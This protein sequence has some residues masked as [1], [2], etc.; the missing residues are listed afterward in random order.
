M[1]NKKVFPFATLLVICLAAIACE[2]SAGMQLAGG[3]VSPSE[4]DAGQTEAISPTAKGSP[5]SHRT[6]TQAFLDTMRTPV[7]FSMG[8]FELYA[9]NLVVLPSDNR[10]AMYTMAR[11]RM[12]AAT[13]GTRSQFQ[14]DYSFGY[15]QYNRRREVHS[16]EHT[17]IM[18]YS[19]Q[20][21]PNTSLHI[22]DDFRSAR[23]DRSTL[24]TS[25][26]PVLYQPNFAQAL[27]LPGERFTNNSLMT[28]LTYRA[29]KRS[30]VTLFSSYDFWRYGGNSFGNAHGIQAGIRAD[31]QM[32]K[33]FF[34]QSSYSHYLNKM[35]RTFQT[36]N[37]HRLQIGGFKFK[38]RRSVE[39]YVSGGADSTRFLDR[40]R[41]VL[42]YEGGISKQAGSTL[43]SLVYHRGLSLE[44][45]PQTTLDGHIVSGSLSQWLSRRV[46]IN[47]TAAYTRGTS[48][49][50][51]SR[52]NYLGANSELDVVLQR[53]LLYSVQYS[54]LS[55]RGTSLSSVN[56]HLARYTVSTG[57]QLVLPSLGGRQQ[58][59]RQLN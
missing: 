52:L 28:G 17:A 58:G 30:N 31:F 13:R 51:A 50:K 44:V 21:S 3:A 12:F 19:Y 47:A 4:G 48:L 41:N 40:Q 49:D 2:E 56:L 33:W 25:S 39:V 38:L 34:L 23:N 15:R 6:M 59:V 26:T 10:S 7:G 43:I 24:P 32:N 42:N 46:N 37:I 45:G 14:F 9:P 53:H 8:F 20:L 54:Y 16:D 11:P 57:F 29:G 18:S 22:S 5:V 36:T 1:L 35:P 27:Y 55:Q